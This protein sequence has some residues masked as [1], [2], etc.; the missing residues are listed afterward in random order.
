MRR[1]LVTAVGNRFEILFYLAI[2]TGMRQGELFGLKWVDIDWSRSKINVRRQVQRLKG[3]GAF[4]KEPKTKAANRIIEVGNPTIDKLRDQYQHQMEL[5]VIAG[6][7]WKDND[8]IFST[9][10]GTPLDNSNVL[11]EF[12]S[13]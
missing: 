2:E 12:Y 11:K 10:I 7:N 9:T 1:F 5:R 8:L 4:F 3:R 6:D 13:I